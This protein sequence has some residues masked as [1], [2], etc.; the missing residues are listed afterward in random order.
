MA[1]FSSSRRPPNNVSRYVADLNL[2]QPT[3]A[4]PQQDENFNIEDDLAVFTNAEFFDFDIGDVIDQQPIVY[5]PSQEERARRENAAHKS[6]GKGVDY[7]HSTFNP[8]WQNAS[9]VAL[10]TVLP[11]QETLF[12]E[13]RDEATA[14]PN[15][16][17]VRRQASLPSPTW[18]P[19]WRAPPRP[20]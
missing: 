18:H 8:R 7:G 13:W 4:L 17:M 19:T 1:G 12:A 11:R 16:N 14:I 6:H 15:A 20:P 2:I 3:D 5:D 9:A 10:G